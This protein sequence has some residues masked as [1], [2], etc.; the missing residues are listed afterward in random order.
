VFDGFGGGFAPGKGGVAGD[1]DAGNGDG[2]EA[3]EPEAADDDRAGIALVGLGDLLGGEGF[4]DGN[5]AVEVVGVGG[6]EAGN[7]AA[8]LSPGG[9]ELGVGVDDAADLGELAVEEGVCVEVA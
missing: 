1:Q 4:G 2:V 3:L 6:A 7:G 8:G 9:G 5:G